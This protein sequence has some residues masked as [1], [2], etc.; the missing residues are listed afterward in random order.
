ML[1]SLLDNLKKYLVTTEKYDTPL[2]DIFCSFLLLLPVR[3][4][5]SS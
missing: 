2:Y 3:P 5:Y 1:S 4:K